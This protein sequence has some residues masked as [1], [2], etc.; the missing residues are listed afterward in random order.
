MEVVWKDVSST[1]GSVD[2]QASRVSSIIACNTILLVIATGGLLVRLFVRLRYLSG[3]NFDDLLCVVSWVRFLAPLNL[4]MPSQILTLRCP[5]SSHLFCALCVSGVSCHESNV[6][7]RLMKLTSLT[8]TV[9]RY[10]YGK[11]IATIHSSEKLEMFLKVWDILMN[12]SIYMLT[13][14]H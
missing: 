4:L 1:G 9:T 10:G 13:Q 12:E 6:Y 11:H 8:P 2:L 5:R 3:I 7:T 14:F